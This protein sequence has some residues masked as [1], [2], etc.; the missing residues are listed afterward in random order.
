MRSATWHD[1][2]FVDLGGGAPAFED[3]VAPLVRR[4]DGLDLGRLHHL[5]TLDFGEVTAKAWRPAAACCRRCGRTP[6][7][8]SRNSW[9]ID[10]DERC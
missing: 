9:W 10:Y 4:L 5:V 7:A 3:F 2:I 1:W 8:A 6:Y